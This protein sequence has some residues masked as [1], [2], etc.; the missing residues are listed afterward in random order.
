MK[1][2]NYYIKSCSRLRGLAS[3]HSEFPPLRNLPEHNNY[4]KDSGGSGW[5]MSL[6]LEHRRQRR[7][8][9][10]WKF[11]ASLVQL[12]CSRPAK[13]IQ[14]NPIFFFKKSLS[15]KEWKFI[16]ILRY[17]STATQC[18]RQNGRAENISTLQQEV[19]EINQL[20]LRIIYG[21]WS[22]EA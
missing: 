17:V 15:S 14:W 10:F 21:M 19:F 13:V 20:L 8:A 4:L 9:D 22:L 6:I 16:V 2:L 18:S 7:K 11:R 12:V 3:L 1:V 5:C